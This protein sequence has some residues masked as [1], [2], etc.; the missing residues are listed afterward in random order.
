M[1]DTHVGDVH[2]FSMPVA[3]YVMAGTDEDRPKPVPVRVTVWVRLPSA[4]SGDTDETVASGGV[5]LMMIGADAEEV[6]PASMDV[7]TLT[8]WREPASGFDTTGTVIVTAVARVAVAI[9]KTSLLVDAVYAT[10]ETV[11]VPKPLA[12]ETAGA[13]SMP[14]PNTPIVTVT[15]V[16]T[17]EDCG[18]KPMVSVAAEPAIVL[19]VTAVTAVGPPMVSG[20]AA[21]T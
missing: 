3:P 21:A 20:T 19:L 18:V 9:V 13:A 10:S 7:S 4:S 16:P 1:V 11:V 15:V 2:V 12:S 17:M 6:T 5:P 14:A 8:V